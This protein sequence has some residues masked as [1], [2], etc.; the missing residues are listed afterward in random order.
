MSRAGKSK[1]KKFRVVLLVL[2]AY[3]VAI[4]FFAGSSLEGTYVYPGHAFNK[5]SDSDKDEVL[6]RILLIGDAG[7]PAETGEEPVLNALTMQASII[8]EK[9]QIIFLGD[10]IYPRGLPD[11]GDP[12]RADAERR[13]VQQIYVAEKSKAG[14]IFIPGNH[15]WDKDGE[16]GWGRIL[17]QQKFIDGLNL[18]KIKFSPKAGCPGP[19]VFDI[20]SKV[21]LIILDTQWWLH[22]Y[23]KPEA[24]DSVC[25][26]CTEDEIIASLDSGIQSANGRFVVVAAHHPLETYG[27]HGG[28]FEWKD[29]IFP[30]R[31]INENLWIPL[32]VIGSLYPLLRNMGIA[33]VDLSHKS[34]QNLKTKLEKVFTKYPSSLI[35]V[36]G[37]EHSLQVL[38]GISDNLYLVSGYGTSDHREGLMTGDKTLFAASYPGFMQLDF[39]KSGKIR[40]DVFSPTMSDGGPETR[41]SRW[42]RD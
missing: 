17:N 13:L 6:S 35:Y 10:N 14:G 25:Y 31:H 42:V 36:T 9:T 29:H 2:I 34:Y 8:P 18:P 3:T 30:L 38:N 24:S 12:E 15:D 26:P 27:H 32:P 39:L 28:Y 16:A 33:N 21:R 40:L 5:G 41:F 1:S 7:A 19:E 37:H 20:N 11:D 4:Y 23:G 22:Q